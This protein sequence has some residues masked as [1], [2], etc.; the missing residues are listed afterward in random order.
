MQWTE[1]A[2]ERAQERFPGADM[3]VLYARARRAGK[4]TKRRIKASCPVSAR[5][6]MSSGFVG[7]Y[8][9]VTR[10][11]IVFV[12]QAPETVVTVFDMNEPP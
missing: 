2:L 5:K 1:H 6:W 12:M 4:K 11:G 3:L 8:Y 10:D 9:L 7:R